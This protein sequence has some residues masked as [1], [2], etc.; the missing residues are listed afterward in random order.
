[1]CGV[2]GGLVLPAIALS[3]IGAAGV[4]GLVAGLC[5]AGFVLLLCGELLERSL[6]FAAVSAPRMPGPFA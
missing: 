4:D 1:M 2:L 5:L 6:F 3:S